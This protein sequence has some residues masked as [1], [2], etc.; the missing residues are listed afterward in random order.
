MTS[1]FIKSEQPA[2]AQN[3]FAALSLIFLAP[4]I[5]GV[6]TG[7]TRISYFYV[8][9]LEMMVLGCG[10]LIIREAA[11]R[12]RAGWTSTLLLGLGLSIAEE[13]VILQTSLAPPPWPARAAT[14]GRLWGI[15]W[16]YLLFRLGFESVWGVLV[17]IQVTELVFPKWRDKRW[18]RDI[19]LAIA[20][21]VFLLGSYVRWFSWNKR[22]RPM[23]LHE[24]NY[25]PSRMT[26]LAGVAAIVLLALAAYVV[27]GVGQTPRRSVRWVPPAWAVC[28]VVML[29][30]YPWFRL[31]AL[32]FARM[33]SHSFWIPMLREFCWAAFVYSIIRLWASAERW[34]DIH[35]W[36]LVFGATL[37]IMAMGFTGSEAWPQIDLVGKVVFN[38]VAIAGFLFL[39]LRIRRRTATT[40]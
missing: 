19:G 39:A 36:A 26:I 15:S 37:L 32:I 16:I 12:W 28:I 9:V 35:R 11:Q 1:H 10:T 3:L 4:F 34:Q 24:P 21:V 7:E 31:T 23:V 5:A 33:S 18:L 40:P 30:G 13:F 22:V 6:L 2:S 17:P 25:T 14:Y 20:G 38:V 27:R 8:F 29:F